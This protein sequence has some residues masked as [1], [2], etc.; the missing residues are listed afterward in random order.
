MPTFTIDK[1]IHDKLD[2]IEIFKLMNKSHFNLFLGKAGS[3]KSSLCVSFLNSR[4]AFK[5]CFHN[6]FLFCPSNSRASIKNDFWGSNLDPDCIFDDLN[7][8]NLQ[9]VYEI[10]KMMHMMILKL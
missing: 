4:D 7:V 2:D 9:Y 10:A 6:I 5:K 3:G 8:E 1:K